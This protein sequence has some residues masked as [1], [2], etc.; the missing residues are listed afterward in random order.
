MIVQAELS[1]VPFCT[2]KSFSKVWGLFET[3]SFHGCLW[4]VVTEQNVQELC[5]FILKSFWRDAEICLYVHDKAEY[6]ISAC[7]WE[8]TGYICSKPWMTQ[9]EGR[10]WWISLAST[11]TGLTSSK[12]N[13]AGVNWLL[14][15]SLLAWK[16]SS[17]LWL[18]EKGK[19][20]GQQFCISV[21][22]GLS[23][24]FSTSF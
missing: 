4:C 20:F 6:L 10:L 23:N 16:V 7:L 17:F 5:I 11:G 14:T 22:E 19:R 13:V 9:L 21:P 3:V 8:Y 18:E 2:R 24:G 15:C 1:S 12:G